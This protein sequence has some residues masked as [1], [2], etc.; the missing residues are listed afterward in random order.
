MEGK[1]KRRIKDSVFTMLFA[2]QTNILE[3]YRSLHPEDETITEEELTTITLETALVTSI[4]NDLGLQARDS[5][6]ILMEAQ[7]TFS[8]NLPFRIL[9]YLAE[10]LDRYVSEH[11]MSRYAKTPIK[12]PRP[13]LYV[14]YTGK[15]KVPPVI[16]LSDLFSDRLEDSSENAKRQQ[17]IRKKYGWIEIEVRTIRKTGNGDILDQYV[18]FCEIS[19]GMREKYG[20]T[21]EAVRNTIDRCMEDGILVDFLSSRRTEVEENMKHMFDEEAALLSHDEEVRQE[22]EQS[23]IEKGIRAMVEVLK[24][25]SQSKESI[26]K[27]I[28]DKFSLQPQVAADKVALYW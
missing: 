14:V 19:D 7:S 5:I 11:K 4:Y 21:I 1:M 25:V 13:E 17:E 27:V 9:L 24:G 22:G 10:T 3:L 8:W 16:R 28:A 6:I 12:I 18:H 26:A 20:P 23:G 15:D 2:N